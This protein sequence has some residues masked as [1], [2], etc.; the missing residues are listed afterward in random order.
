MEQFIGLLF[1][2]WH[3][4]SWLNLA[5]TSGCFHNSVERGAERGLGCKGLNKHL[6]NC[7]SSYFMESIC[8]QWEVPAELRFRVQTSPPYSRAKRELSVL[9]VRVHLVISALSWPSIRDHPITVSPHQKL[10]ASGFWSNP[11]LEH[12]DTH[13][14]VEFWKQKGLWGSILDMGELTLKLLRKSD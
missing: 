4:G 6:W 2:L 9:Q 14:F 5:I 3:H 11:L 1:H 13:S 12:T 8:T 7:E 10:Q